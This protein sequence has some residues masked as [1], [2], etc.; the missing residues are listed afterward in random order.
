MDTKTLMD[1]VAM[2]DARLAEIE[3]F[4]E[5]DALD[6]SQ[7]NYVEGCKFVLEELGDTL[8]K[9]IE[10]DISGMENSTGE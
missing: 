7:L 1:V 8:Q 10:A 9:G 2:I 4:L 3:I 6:H 5:S